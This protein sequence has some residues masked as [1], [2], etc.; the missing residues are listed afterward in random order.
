[1]KKLV[2][3]TLVLGLAVT[4]AS[5]DQVASPTN[6]TIWG[7]TSWYCDGG[8]PGEVFSVDMA[9]GAVGARYA[10]PEWGML[11]AIACV[12]PTEAIVANTDRATGVRQLSKVDLT[13]GA[14][15]AS[16][17]YRTYG[18]LTFE[19]GVLV[20]MTGNP[21]DD[22][23]VGLPCETYAINFAAGTDT[24]LA[25][26]DSTRLGSWNNWIAKNPVDGLWT[27]FHDYGVDLLK[28]TDPSIPATRTGIKTED[29]LGGGMYVA[30]GKVICGNGVNYKL[31]TDIELGM[32]NENWIYDLSGTLAG[33]GLGIYG[34]SAAIPEPATLSL[35]VLGGLALVRR[36]RK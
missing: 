24:L 19:D 7:V 32:G 29:F 22:L 4:A 3:M 5:A 21:N 18:G 13:T 34:L 35:L 10:K 36:R 33:S 11:T 8:V 14:T 6:E 2:L 28:T 16:K 31:W 17:S 30:N 20:G 12:S 9:T 26:H 27:L 1:M 25:S 15:I 23:G